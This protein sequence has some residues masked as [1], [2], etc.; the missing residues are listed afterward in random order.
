MII[1]SEW[2]GERI[3]GG[4]GGQRKDWEREID[5]GRLVEIEIVCVRMCAC[6]RE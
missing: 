5:G 6:E 2:G 3:G 4:G 1:R